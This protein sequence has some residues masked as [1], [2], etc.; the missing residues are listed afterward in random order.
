MATVTRLHI[1]PQR[2]EHLSFKDP[3]RTGQPVVLGPGLCQSGLGRRRGSDGLCLKQCRSFRAE[4]GEKEV[5]SARKC[6]NLKE[7]EA[8]LQRG[9]GF[10]SS[11]RITILGG[12]SLARGDE[13]RNALA[14]VEEVFSSVS[15]ACIRFVSLCLKILSLLSGICS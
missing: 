14:K 6:G 5:E 15:C 4:E 7:T 1:F 3:G 8:K 11:L 13:Y 12:F 9:I 10:W 2:F